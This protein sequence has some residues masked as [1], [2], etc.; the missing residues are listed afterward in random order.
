MVYITPLTQSIHHLSYNQLKYIKYRDKIK[1]R[2]LKYYYRNRK[3]VLK[4]QI[5]YK[6]NKYKTDPIF[7]EKDNIRKLATHHISL[8]DKRCEICLTYKDLQR[9]HPDYSEPLKVI[10]LCR[11]CHNSI[12]RIDD[13]LLSLESKQKHLNS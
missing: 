5:L 7:H 3:Q 10:I 13:K 8:K 1:E 4:K 11:N 6:T 2:S 9:H 12:H